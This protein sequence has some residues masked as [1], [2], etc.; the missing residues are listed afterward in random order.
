MMVTRNQRKKKIVMRR[1]GTKKESRNTPH[2]IQS[3]S[4]AIMQ[5]I[6]L[7]QENTLNL[8]LLLLI[9]RTAKLTTLVVLCS[10]ENHVF[11]IPFIPQKVIEYRLTTTK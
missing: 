5:S 8:F 11:C 10:T 3:D 1:M 9:T 4:K 2:R 6:L 7:G